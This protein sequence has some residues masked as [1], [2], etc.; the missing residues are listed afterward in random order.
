MT[1]Q[2]IN[3]PQVTD[4]LLA[5]VD[6]LTGPLTYELIA[7]GRSNLTFAVTDAAGR[8]VVLRRPPI[9]HV[10]ASAHDMGREHRIISALRD[11]PVPVP[12]TLGYCTDE[13][14]NERPFY[15]MEFVE[16]YVFRVNP[17]R[18]GPQGGRRGL[19]RR[20]R[21]DPRRRRRCGRAR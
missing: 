6:G 21:G 19:D 5:N 3:E 11:T 10:L 17:G 13:S 18:G 7:G 12:L 20:A 4:W 9:S 14:V 15:V 16:G 2:G 8:K 1:T